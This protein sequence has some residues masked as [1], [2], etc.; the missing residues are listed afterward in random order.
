MRRLDWC[1]KSAEIGCPRLELN[2]QIPS[3]LRRVWNI[4]LSGIAFNIAHNA[5]PQRMDHHRGVTPFS[6]TYEYRK[7]GVPRD[8]KRLRE[9]GFFLPHA[10]DRQSENTT[11]GHPVLSGLFLGR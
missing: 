1:L 6:R 11:D 2:E 8:L 4:P 10:G 9:G 5:W 7:K 3:A